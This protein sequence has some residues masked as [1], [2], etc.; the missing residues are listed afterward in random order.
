MTA[1]IV[2]QVSV[3][4]ANLLLSKLSERKPQKQPDKE[5]KVIFGK[6]YLPGSDSEV[7]I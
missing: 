3:E 5:T 2:P 7:T 4:A 6:R 1:G